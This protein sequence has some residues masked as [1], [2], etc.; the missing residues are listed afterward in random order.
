MTQRKEQLSNESKYT[1]FRG[2]L[3]QAEKKFTNLISEKYMRHIVSILIAV[4]GVG[5]RGKTKTV[6][7]AL[8]SDHHRTTISRFLRNEK[9]NDAPG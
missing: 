7:I 8:H 2:D 6:N 9:W 4:F 3:Q 1:P 5:Y